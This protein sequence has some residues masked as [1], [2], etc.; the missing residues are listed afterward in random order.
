MLKPAQLR[1]ALTDA[2]PVLQTSPDTLRMFV[3]NGRIVSTLASSL[4]FEYQY[5]VELLI[6]DFAHDCDLIIV[7]ILAWLREH[8]PDIMATPDKQQTGYKFKADMLNDGSYDIAVYLQLTERV[9]VKQIDAG[10]YVEHVPEPQLPEPVERP[11]ELYLHGELV[12]QWN[13]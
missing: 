10:L 7:P 2:V 6:T 11:R 1:K 5:Q 8:Q 4:S 13:E 3:D 12:S 9:I